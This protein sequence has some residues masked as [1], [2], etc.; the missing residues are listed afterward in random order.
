M[1]AMT[2]PQRIESM[3]ALPLF[4]RKAVTGIGLANVR[5]VISR[6]CG[7]TWAEGKLDGVATF[8]FSLNQ[9]NYKEKS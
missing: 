3:I 1:M 2:D 4:A 6:H 5:R 8:Y 7:R 9:S